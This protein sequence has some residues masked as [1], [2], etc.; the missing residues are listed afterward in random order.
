M[1]DV[2]HKRCSH[3]SCTRQPNF[4]VKGSKTAAFCK[5][6]A[7]DD[8]VNVSRKRCSHDACT[9]RPSFNFEGS[10]K[11]MFCKQHAQDGMVCVLSLI[12][13]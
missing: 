5:Q 10:K 7:E 6:H 11:A 3:D 8:M 13:I 9:T 1:V 2:Y 4:N 12:H